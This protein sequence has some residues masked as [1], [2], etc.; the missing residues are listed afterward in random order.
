[1]MAIDLG[2]KSGEGLGF[3]YDQVLNFCA[4]LAP[5]VQQ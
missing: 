4:I 3:M 2:S 1:M 5:R